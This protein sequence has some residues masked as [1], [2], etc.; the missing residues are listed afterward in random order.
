MLTPICIV[1]IL[2]FQA[3]KRGHKSVVR[4]LLDYGANFSS[5]HNSDTPIK[6]AN[7]YNHRDIAD[8]IN[9][10]ISK[11]VCATLTLPIG[12]GLFASV[13]NDSVGF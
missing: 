9:T 3:V 7:H 6:L 10:H 4:V 2:L 5:P 13:L 1:Y 8:I 12:P 11:Y